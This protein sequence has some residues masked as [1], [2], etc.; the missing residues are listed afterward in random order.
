[1]KIKLDKNGRLP[2]SFFAPFVDIDKVKYYKFSKCKDP[3]KGWKVVFYDKNKKKLPINK[4][5]R[6]KVKKKK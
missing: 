3:S 6:K 1:M 2:L 5:V 4:V